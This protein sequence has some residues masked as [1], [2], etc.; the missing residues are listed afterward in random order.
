MVNPVLGTPAKPG[1]AVSTRDLILINFLNQTGIDINILPDGIQNSAFRQFALGDA[2]IARAKDQIERTDTDLK[3]GE[4]NA[5]QLLEATKHDEKANT[6]I[7][8]QFNQLRQLTESVNTCKQSLSSLKA[9]KP[10]IFQKELE[11]IA[12]APNKEEMTTRGLNHQKTTLVA[13]KNQSETATHLH[14][15]VRAACDI[16][17]EYRLTTKMVSALPKKP[18]P[19]AGPQPGVKT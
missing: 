9:E 17:N 19:S 13:I 15:Q 1:E 18:T 6:V 5:L 10:A 16:L 2:R 12:A 7:L 8:A 14:T 11:T 3:E 4:A